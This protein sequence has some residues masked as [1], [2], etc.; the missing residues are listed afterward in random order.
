MSG[1]EEKAPAPSSTEE[2]VVVEGVDPAH[3]LTLLAASRG[4]IFRESS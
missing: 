2:E 4:R 3:L 1:L